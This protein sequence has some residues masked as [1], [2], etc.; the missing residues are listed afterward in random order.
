MTPS[1][2]LQRFLGD[3]P[4]KIAVLR[5][6]VRRRVIVIVHGNDD[7][8]ETANLWQGISPDDSCTLAV[9]TTHSF[10]V[11][12]FI[13]QPKGTG[14]DLLLRGADFVARHNHFFA[15]AAALGTRAPQDSRGFQRIPGFAH[16]RALPITLPATIADC[17]VIRI[18]IR[19]FYARRP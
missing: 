19:W 3:N 16:N 2:L 1:I 4:F 18:R 17:Y 7:T 14:V 11:P 13:L 6:K 12:T 8:Q 5:M 15:G 10:Y 9:K